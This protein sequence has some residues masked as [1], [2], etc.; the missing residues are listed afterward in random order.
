MDIP[1]RGYV[2][3]AN[4]SDPVVISLQLTNFQSLI[5]PRMNLLVFREDPKSH[6]PVSRTCTFFKYT[7]TANGKNDISGKKIHFLQRL[8]FLLL[9]INSRGI[10]LTFG[11]VKF[12]GCN[13]PTF[14]QACRCRC[15]PVKLTISVLFF[16]GLCQKTLFY[17]FLSH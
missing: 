15:R 10:T 5:G 3:V 8:A 9:H 4:T 17:H 7:I 11:I 1:L 14:Q 16:S 12:G 13:T 2:M 6:L